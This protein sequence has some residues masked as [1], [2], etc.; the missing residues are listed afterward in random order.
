MGL[1]MGLGTSPGRTMRF[2]SWR[3][4]G[5]GMEGLV[6]EGAGIGNLHNLPQVH[7]HD[8]VGH[9]LHHRKVVGNKEVGEPQVL[10]DLL[11]QVEH[12]GLDGDIQGG[13][14]L[15]A[16]EH[17]RPDLQSAGD[18]EALA[19]A[20]GKLVGIAQEVIGLDVHHLQHVL[21]DPLPLLLAADAM[22]LQRLLEGGVNLL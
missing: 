5:T 2:F 19:L 16:D 11:H 21:H 4:W 18:A 10:L 1:R 14:R 3:I 20:A 17:L 13:N 8:A 6:V 12:L 15:V 9:I 7:D 22:D